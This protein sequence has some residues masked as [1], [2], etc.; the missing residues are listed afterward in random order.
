MSTLPW[1][2]EGTLPMGVADPDI[3]VYFGDTFTNDTTGEVVLQ[4]NHTK[5]MT[6]RL[7]ELTGFLANPVYTAP[8]APTAPPP[9][10]GEFLGA[11]VPGPEA[12]KN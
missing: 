2:I 11:V 12:V 10:S 5:R 3:A 7:S 8:A 4:Q 6:V 1:R 9:P